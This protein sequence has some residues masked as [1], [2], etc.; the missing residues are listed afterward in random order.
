MRQDDKLLCWRAILLATSFKLCFQFNDG[1][2]TETIFKE[3]LKLVLYIFHI[4]CVSYGVAFTL[5][6]E[7]PSPPI[8]YKADAC[9]ITEGF[10]DETTN[11]IPNHYTTSWV[12]DLGGHCK[13]PSIPPLMC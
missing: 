11:I 2:L 1:P 13:L 7:M 6:I 3:L 5:N 4:L 12:I 8:A 10:A 9:R